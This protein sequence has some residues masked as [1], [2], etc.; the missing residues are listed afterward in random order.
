MTLEIRRFSFQPHIPNFIQCGDLAKKKKKP[1]R[2][3]NNSSPHQLPLAHV[4]ANLPYDIYLIARFAS[5][6]L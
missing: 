3:S 1:F 5:L 4:H 6:S 2:E